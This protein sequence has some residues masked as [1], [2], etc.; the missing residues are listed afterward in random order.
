M[1]VSLFWF[2]NLLDTLNSPLTCMLD[3]V[4]DVWEGVVA[5]KFSA[6][7]QEVGYY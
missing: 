5:E 6:W 3:N 2:D 7:M 1:V 4:V